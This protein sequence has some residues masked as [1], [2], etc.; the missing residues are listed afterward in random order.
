MAKPRTPEIR[1]TTAASVGRRTAVRALAALVREHTPRTPLRRIC[2]LLAEK[3]IAAVLTL[4]DLVAAMAATRRKRAPA[5][6]GS[7]RRAAPP[8]VDTPEFWDPPT[9]IEGVEVIVAPLPRELRMPCTAPRVPEEPRLPELVNP[10]PEQRLRREIF[11]CSMNTASRGL[12]EHLQRLGGWVTATQVAESLDAE[13]RALGSL[14]AIPVPVEETLLEVEI[15]LQRLVQQ[16]DA[17]QRRGRYI[18]AM[19]SCI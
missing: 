3:Q 1:R 13:L 14:L 12:L 2:Q 9:I 15:L 4:A 8:F 18:A 10:S 7:S 6:P 11:L 17:R 19:T 16:G 5:S